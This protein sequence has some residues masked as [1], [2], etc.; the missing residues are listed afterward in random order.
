MILHQRQKVE[1]TESKEGFSD[2]PFA[3]K[4]CDADST[5]QQITVH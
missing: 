4:T 5:V 2:L 3:Y 1:V